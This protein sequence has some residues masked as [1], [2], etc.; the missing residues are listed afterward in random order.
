MWALPCLGSEGLSKVIFDCSWML[1]EKV[2]ET[3][4]FEY[5][6]LPFEGVEGKGHRSVGV[7]GVSTCAVRLE[8]SL[9]V[10]AGAVHL[11]KSS[12]LVATGCLY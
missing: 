6:S 8:T 1:V 9:Q 7:R 12:A 11:A 10:S 2:G 3:W 4:V 5:W